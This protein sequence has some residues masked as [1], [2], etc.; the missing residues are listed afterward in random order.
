MKL[1]FVKP[2]TKILRRIFIVEIKKLAFIFWVV[3]QYIPFLGFLILA[4]I[5]KQ[6]F[7]L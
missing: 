2:M 6:Q 5:Q 1:D 7:I 4:V 3:Y